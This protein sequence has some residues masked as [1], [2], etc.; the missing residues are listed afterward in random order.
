MNR[1]KSDDREIFVVARVGTARIQ[2]TT[3]AM[4]GMK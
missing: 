1:T 3:R 4:P 2:V